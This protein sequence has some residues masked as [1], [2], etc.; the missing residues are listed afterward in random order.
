MA[1][2]ETGFRPAAPRAGGRRDDG[3]W[4]NRIVELHVLTEHGDVEAA[5]TA[6]RWLATDDEARRLW[7]EVDQDCR[8]VRGVPSGN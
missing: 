1:V 3:G 7:D 4:R 2:E 6:Q 8:K 5:S